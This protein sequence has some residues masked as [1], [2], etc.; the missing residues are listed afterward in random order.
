MIAD[1]LETKCLYDLLKSSVFW[2]IKNFFEVS[3][4]QNIRSFSKA[5]VSQ[6][7]RKAFS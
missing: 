3:V 6:G 2:N 1:V 4:S 7:I 5:S